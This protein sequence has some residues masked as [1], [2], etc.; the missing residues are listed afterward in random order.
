MEIKFEQYNTSLNKELIFAISH[1]LRELGFRKESAHYFIKPKGESPTLLRINTLNHWYFKHYDWNGVNRYFPS[2]ASTIK[3]CGNKIIPLYTEF[4]KSG[5]I[6]TVPND[7]QIKSFA[8]RQGFEIRTGN[9]SEILI[10]LIAAYRGKK[11]ESKAFE[12]YI[13]LTENKQ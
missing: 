11:N 8:E 7:V 10:D 5:Y 12:K 4:E 9:L 13:K 6:C 2:M 3:Y 1:I